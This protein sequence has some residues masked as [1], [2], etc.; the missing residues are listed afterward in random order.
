MRIALGVA[1]AAALAACGP[2]VGDACTTDRDCGKGV[3]LQ[4][5]T[6]P[7]GYCSLVCQGGGTGGCPNGS[8]C[9]DDTSG[10]GG[11]RHCRLTCATDQDCRSGYTCTGTQGNARVCLGP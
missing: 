6:A 11:D 8:T 2:T 3:C 7:G 4:G 9:A 5:T 1:A 10:Q